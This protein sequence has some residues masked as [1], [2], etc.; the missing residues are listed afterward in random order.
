MFSRF[1]PALLSQ[2]LTVIVDVLAIL[3]LV[4]G[5]TAV[6]AVGE[7]PVLAEIHL[8]RFFGYS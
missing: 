1:Y 7:C 8:D 6:T 3:D 2:F 4:L 5:A